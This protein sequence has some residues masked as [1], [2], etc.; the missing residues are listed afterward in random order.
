[1]VYHYVTEVK[2]TTEGYVVMTQNN[3]VQPQ[4]P[5]WPATTFSVARGRIQEKSSNLRL[6]EK[7]VRLHLS[8]WI[9]CAGKMHLHKN[10]E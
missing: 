4:A 10:N 6:A 8:H 2:R 9:A 7:R 1:M 5:V 3:V